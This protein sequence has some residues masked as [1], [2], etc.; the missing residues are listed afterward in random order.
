M[1][2]VQEQAV[3][4]AGKPLRARP[5][6]PQSLTVQSSAS[7]AEDHLFV[8]V[9][10]SGPPV[11]LSLQLGDEVAPGHAVARE[12][13]TVHRFAIG[14]PARDRSVGP[15]AASLIAEQGEVTVQ[16]VR[17]LLVLGE[18]PA[19][20]LAALDR[21]HAVLGAAPLVGEEPAFAGSEVAVASV[22]RQEVPSGAFESFASSGLTAEVEVVFA[23]PRA[24][25]DAR[26]LFDGQELP[27]RAADG[28]RRRWRRGGASGAHEGWSH[29][30]SFD[31]VGGGAGA[32]L[33]RTLIH[34]FPVVQDPVTM[35]DFVAATGLHDREVYAS[36][37]GQVWTGPEPRATVVLPMALAR[38]GRLLVE[39]TSFG[40]CRT[41]QDVTLLVN[42]TAVHH[43][44]ERSADGGGR[45][46]ADFPAAAD[47]RLITEIQIFVHRMH[48][49]PPDPRR[50]GIGLG[51]I[52]IQTPL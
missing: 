22:R 52:E 33:S 35:T 11:R 4:A 28:L 8:E 40:E 10:T 15:L 23:D 16:G 50:L 32:V 45:L 3:A 29:L 2:L 36:G 25:K 51:G 39:V 47:P 38:P 5:G 1:I 34:R 37:E 6:A 24:A 21:A 20:A 12:D 31:G 48:S 49:A 9:T 46:L 42:G 14:G 17:T 30:I 13:A 43:R 18:Q 7:T 26:C 19:E 27:I 41:A 44:I